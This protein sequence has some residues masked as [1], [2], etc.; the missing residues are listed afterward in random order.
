MEHL[1]L[2]GAVII[3]IGGIIAAIGASRDVRQQLGLTQRL[4]AK[5]DEIA[6]LNQDLAAKS[7][8]IAGLAKQGLAAV[9]GGESFAYLQPL[10]RGGRVRYFVRQQGKHPTY[11][12][13][14]RMEEVSRPSGEE[15]RRLIFGPVE[16]GRTLLRGS[17]FDWTYPDPTP[18]DNREWPLIF[19]EPPGSDATAREFRIELAARNGIVVQELRIR[20]ARGGWHTDSS[21]IERPGVGRLMLPDDF[22]EA[23]AQ[24]ADGNRM[25]PKPTGG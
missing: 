18:P 8:E 13:V 25:P 2:I 15:K 21:V 20:P 16:V 3:A 23:Q 7:E 22:D 6:A 5:S 11:D 4:A 14:I 10:R 12:L 24:D 1:T 19:L 9:T 17:G